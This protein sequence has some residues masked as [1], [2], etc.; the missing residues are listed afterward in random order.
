MNLKNRTGLLGGG[1]MIAILRSRDDG[2]LIV[3]E[4]SARCA[5]EAQ[6]HSTEKSEKEIRENSALVQKSD[7]T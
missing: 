4:N 6:I 7:S 5:S 3:A 1:E 2:N